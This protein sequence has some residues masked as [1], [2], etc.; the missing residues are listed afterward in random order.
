M[1]TEGIALEDIAEEG[2]DLEGGNDLV[3]NQ[4]ELVI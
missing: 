3:S 2:F 4:S 1:G